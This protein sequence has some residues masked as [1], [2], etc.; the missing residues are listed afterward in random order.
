[1]TGEADLLFPTFSSKGGEGDKNS[2]WWNASI[3]KPKLLG[4]AT[5]LLDRKSPP[6]PKPLILH[7]HR[8]A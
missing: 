5:D 6:P 2:T 7:I 4:N 3:V 8:S 1:M